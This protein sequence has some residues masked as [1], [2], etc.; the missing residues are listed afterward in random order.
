[1]EEK[2]SEHE[3]TLVRQKNKLIGGDLLFL[4]SC[5]EIINA[6]DRE[7]FKHVLVIHASDL[8]K[9]RGW[10]PHI[11]EIVNGACEM[12]VSLLEAD[13]AVDTGDIWHK[14]KLKIPS[15]ALYDEIN[16][17]LFDAEIALMDYAVKNFGKVIPKPQGESVEPS[18]WSKRTPK[19]SELD[20]KG[21]IEEQFNLIRVCDPDRFPAFFYK[22]GKK[23]ILKIEADN[24]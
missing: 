1:M 12:T 4:I 6:V 10:S 11:W 22:D 2:S 3:L 19:D 15:T 21:S 17:L 18:Y 8:P 24:E 9:G 20:I 23:F 16:Q 5:S 13:D 14:L 7:K